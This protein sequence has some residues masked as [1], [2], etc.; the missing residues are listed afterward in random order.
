MDF[1]YYYYYYSYYYYAD[2]IDTVVDALTWIVNGRRLVV[3][4][5]LCSVA[6][7][8]EWRVIDAVCALVEDPRDWVARSA[9]SVIT[10]IANYYYKY[11]YYAYFPVF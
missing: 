5:A 4:E 2:I 10:W 7:N 9:A 6:A 11:Y 3:E 1:H 8:C